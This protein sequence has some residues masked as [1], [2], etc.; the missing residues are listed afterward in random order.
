[1]DDL[2]ACFAESSV[3]SKLTP[4]DHAELARIA[5]RRTYQKGQF[6]CLQGDIWSRVLYIASGR[7]GWAM[8]SPDG[9]R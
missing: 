7:L 2:N 8:L 5:V 1:M 9:K 3:F 4:G 6:I